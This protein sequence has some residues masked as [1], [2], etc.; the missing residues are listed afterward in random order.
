MPPRNAAGKGA[1][2]SES[3]KTLGE[4]SAPGGGVEWGASPVPARLEPGP[5]A[6]F[7]DRRCRLCMTPPC[8]GG[9]GV[10]LTGWRAEGTG[11]REGRPIGAA[12]SFAPPEGGWGGLPTSCNAAR[13]PTTDRTRSPPG[14]GLGGAAY[15]VHHRRS[16]AARSRVDRVT[17]TRRG[18]LRASE[19]GTRIGRPGDR[20]SPWERTPGWSNVIPIEVSALQRVIPSMAE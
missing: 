14:G 17:G 7:L 12:V 18:L 19:R 15:S 5:P 3:R 8:E 10:I 6:D 9:R 4:G 16:S 1:A 20:C 2:A 11:A 13:K